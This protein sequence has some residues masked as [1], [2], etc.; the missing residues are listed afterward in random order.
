[1]Q[2][3]GQPVIE[4]PPPVIDR[5][6][7]VDRPPAPPT[8]VIVDA[9]P[10]QG[11][12]QEWGNASTTNYPNSVDDTYINVDAVNYKA[13]EA[14]NVYT[15][16]ANTVANAIILK[17]NIGA[18][19]IGAT[20]FSATALLYLEGHQGSGGDDPYHVGVHRIINRNPVIASTTGATYDGANKWT[21][22]ESF[23][24]AQHDLHVAESH[25]GLAHVGLTTHAGYVSLS[26]THMVSFWVSN[27]G[28]NYGMLVNSDPI[29]TVDSNRF[30]SSSDH[31][32]QDQRPR[33]QIRYLPAPPDTTDP[34][35]SNVA[36]GSLTPSGAT[37]TWDT[38]EPA[39]SQIDYGL[40]ASYG[41]QTVLDAALVL[42]HVH[43]I[44]GLTAGTLYHYRARSADATNNLSLSGN[45]TFTTA[46]ADTTAPIISSVS[47][48]VIGSHTATV[49]WS[50]NEAADR[51][52]EYGPSSS[53]GFL[54]IRHTELVTSHAHHLTALTA[55]T[56][57]HY[58]ALSRDAAGNLATSGTH[59]FTTL[60]V[61]GNW[62][63]EPAG[64]T[65]ITDR[66]F[67]SKVEDGWSDTG[68]SN[69]SIQT[70]ASAP[71]SPS[72]VGEGLYPVGFGGGS[73]SH[74]T[75]RS[76]SGTHIYISFWLQLS[77]NWD[78][79]S[80]GVNKIIFVWIHGN[81]SV[82]FSNQGS[83]AGPYQPQVRLQNIP[84]GTRN[85]VPNINSLST[86][87]GQWYRWEV[88]LKSNTGGNANGEAHW[89]INGTKVGQ[90]TD[91]T[92]SSASQSTTWDEISW[93]PTWGGIG[94]TVSSAMFQRMDHCY[95]S[96]E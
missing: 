95:V 89:W 90:Y 54:T 55:S 42:G 50:T 92:Y 18:I 23:P 31:A 3:L 74:N 56:G 5:P 36:S 78:G 12:F 29:A 46:A 84:G 70:D 72:N 88:V 58:R 8:S 20:I 32:K 38:D 10:V 21:G 9:P 6:P 66:A 52:V 22:P 60:A 17:W 24:L 64:F 67:N 76:I 65:A 85:L 49:T 62:P 7:V 96:R 14:L 77:S 59:V 26:V 57:Y 68:S 86:Q 13:E 71:K 73:G 53:F 45:N 94:G 27:P 63:N 48:S 40:T 37:I 30:F 34:I 61:S 33:L 69:F 79:H 51:Q 91:V 43:H 25:L 11:I 44:G 80:S 47:S 4:V 41:S 87:R 35:I 19:H 16:P 15:W 75:Y 39:S 28:Q 83:G 1:M 82:Y 2:A 93:N 81:P